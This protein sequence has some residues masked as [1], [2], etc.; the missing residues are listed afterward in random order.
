MQ[1]LENDSA[2]I[3]F[4]ATEAEATAAKGNYQTSRFNAVRHGVLSR[5][6]VLPHEDEAEY[7][8]LLAALFE[9][10]QPGGATEM[11]LVEELAGC[12]WR[13]RRV[14]MSEGAAICRGLYDVATDTYHSPAPAAVPFEPGLSSKSDDLRELLSATP[15][16]IAER[17]DYAKRDLEATEKAAAIL[18]KGGANAYDKALKALSPDSGD[19]WPEWVEEEEIQ[20][21][22]GG[23]AAFINDHLLPACIRIEREVRYHQAIK[24]QT[25]GEGLQA[26]RLEK[27]TRYET[28]LD[29]KFER[30]LAM[31]LK[32]K[33]LGMGR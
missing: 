28:H 10:H 5:H 21:N 4:T 25:L 13:K 30:T 20:A 19:W 31:L 3:S 14:L 24:V 9:E 22:A 27:L 1:T 6:T 29:R 15:E 7:R 8:A 32:L 23:L 18:R 26:H 16:Q 11:H 12:V 17:Q 2:V 33:E